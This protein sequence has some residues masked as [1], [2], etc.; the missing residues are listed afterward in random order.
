MDVKDHHVEETTEEARQAENNP[1]MTS[2]LG[3]SITGVVIVLG[4]ALA[5]F[6]AWNSGLF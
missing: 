3:L 4:L 1:G 5:A 2:V 6:I